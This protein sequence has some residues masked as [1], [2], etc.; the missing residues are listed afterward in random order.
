MFN[1]NYKIGDRVVHTRT[2]SVG[3][4]TGY[5]SD[6]SEHYVRVKWDKN[7]G[8]WPAGYVTDISA[9]KKVDE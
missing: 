8:D 9:I 3:T 7:K 4:V 5:P 1:Q 6:Y 2:D